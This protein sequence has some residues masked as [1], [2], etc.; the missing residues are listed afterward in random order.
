MC[1]RCG[2]LRETDD[3]SPVRPAVVEGLLQAVLLVLLAEGDGYG[4]ELAVA[5]EARG[6]LAQPVPPT[7]VYQALRQLAD[8]G[9]LRVREQSSPDGPDRRRY[10]IT[11]AG[12]SHLG[13]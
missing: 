8:E 9:A 4:Y 13:R 10:S 6:L 11:T 3:R 12:R 1:G 7:R 2:C 5:I